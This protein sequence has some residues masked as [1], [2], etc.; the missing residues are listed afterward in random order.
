MANDKK[1]KPLKIYE[2]GE[3]IGEV[4]WWDVKYNDNGKLNVLIKFKLKDHKEG[5]FAR[6]Y[7]EGGAAEWTTKNLYN[8]GFRGKS[9]GDLANDTA[10]DKDQVLHLKIENETYKGKTYSKV[11][12]ANK[13]FVKEYDPADVKK[14]QSVDLRA[15]MAEAKSGDPESK[16]QNTQSQN[17]QQ[18]ESYDYAQA[19]EP[20]YTA[21]DIPF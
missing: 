5:A 21:D 2:P 14:M 7:F 3:Y 1:K 8:C 9:V 4:L 19:E 12:W 18:D 15:Y 6:W 16:K 10:L 13:P 11:T 20:T 17:S